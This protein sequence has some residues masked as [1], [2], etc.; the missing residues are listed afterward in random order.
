MV[1]QVPVVP[2]VLLV[3]VVPQVP[4]VPLV[5]LVPVVPLV[6]LV[7]QVPVVPVVPVVPQ[8]PAVP[9]VPQVP[10]VPVIPEVPVVPL[11]PLVPLVPGNYE[12][13]N[14]MEHGTERGT[15]VRCGP[16]ARLTAR[17]H[18]RPRRAD[19]LRFDADRSGRCVYTTPPK[20]SMYCDSGSKF[21]ISHMP[22]P[23]SHETSHTFGNSIYNTMTTPRLETGPF[24][25]WFGYYWQPSRP[26]STPY[27]RV[28]FR[29]HLRRER[30]ESNQFDGVWWSSTER[31]GAVR[32]VFTLRDNSNQ[33]ELDRSRALV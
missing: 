2:L 10:L 13:R 27:Q 16:R 22:R 4:V 14:G 18:Y 17:L 24:V 23:H 6:P 3:P 11:V 30:S 21:I 31:I 15:G 28:R 25:I 19:S 29:L 8:V 26:P 20:R 12:S 5:L 1:P 9:A 7:P 33:F 32:F